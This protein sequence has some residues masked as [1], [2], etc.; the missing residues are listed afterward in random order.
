MNYE[1]MFLYVRNI[2]EENN[3]I[4]SPKPHQQFRD[5]YMHTRRVY[6]WG[7]RLLGDYDDL[8]KDVIFTSIIFHDSGYAYGQKDHPI[9]SNKIFL[10][11]AEKNNFDKDFIDEVSYIILNHSEKELLKTTDNHNFI[12]MMEADLLD[13][14]GALGILWDLLSAGYNETPSYYSALDE[15]N[16]HSAHI[17]SQDFM[18]SKTAKFYWNNKKR[19]VL[20]FIESINDD[21]FI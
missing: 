6:E 3:A 2:L 14:D 5:R 8:D 16:K 20:E 9:N 4:K 13:E 17:L 12:I 1:D 18:V 15:L 7:R 19:L 21:L 11:Y 10:E